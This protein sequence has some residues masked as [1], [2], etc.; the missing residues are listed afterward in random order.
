MLQ[1]V[2]GWNSKIRLF[3]QNQWQFLSTKYVCL[4]KISGH[5]C[6]Q[7]TSVSAKSLGVPV[8]KIRLFEQNQW[9]YLVHLDAG[10]RRRFLAVLLRHASASLL[11]LTF[12]L[13]FLEALRLPPLGSPILEPYLRRR[14][15]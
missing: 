11:L 12:P 5:T 6:P 15:D 2:K 4:K 9:P 10:R 3:E 14:V 1:R 8:H 13:L 7:N